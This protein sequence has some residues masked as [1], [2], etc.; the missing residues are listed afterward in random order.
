[1]QGSERRQAAARLN[2]VLARPADAPLADAEAPRDVP[3]ARTRLR[4]PYQDRRPNAT[5]HWR[6]Q[7]GADHGGRAHAQLMRASRWPG[8]DVGVVGDP[9]G[10]A[11]HRLRT[12]GRSEHPVAAR[13]P[14]RERERSGGDASAAEA[15][16]GTRRRRNCR[17]SSDRTGPRSTHCASRLP[18]CA[19]RCCRSAQL[20][21]ESAL[22]ATRPAASTSERCSTRSGRSAAHA[23]GPAE[24]ANWNSR[25]GS[26]RSSASSGRI[27]ERPG[28][29]PQ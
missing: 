25:C 15:Q 11:A 22:S 16:A 2:G 24:G 20:T 9:A 14:P 29:L 17:A 12:D 21:F 7:C 1:M 10:H 13:H 6:V 5:R 28:Q 18:S 26:P 19:P 27:Y 3:A 8:P 23:A 4:G